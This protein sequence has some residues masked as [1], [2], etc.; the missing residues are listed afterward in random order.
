M[1][2]NMNDLLS[3]ISLVLVIFICLFFAF[4]TFSKHHAKRLM[5]LESEYYDF[6]DDD[7]DDDTYV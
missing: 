3:M 6:S 4:N 7:S 5:E 2:E 1:I